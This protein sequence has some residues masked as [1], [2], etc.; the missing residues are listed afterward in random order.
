MAVLARIRGN[1]CTILTVCCLLSCC[2]IQLPGSVPSSVSE[3]FLFVTGHATRNSAT[4]GAAS[5]RHSSLEI[6]T[7]HMEYS[8]LEKDLPSDSLSA[9]VIVS[10]RWSNT[11][12]MDFNLEWNCTCN[13]T[14]P[15]PPPRQHPFSIWTTSTIISRHCL[16]YCRHLLV[17]YPVEMGSFHIFPCLIC[18]RKQKTLTLFAA[19][20]VW[21]RVNIAFWA[22]VPPLRRWSSLYLPVRKCSSNQREMGSGNVKYGQ[23]DVLGS[24]TFSFMTLIYA[25]NTISLVKISCSLWYSRFTI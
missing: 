16:F 13:L 23:N 10:L 8:F 22:I 7:C 12:T 9:S 15:P 14:T 5:S 24:T 11:V 18:I 19:G 4:I 3:R 2:F 1:N 6:L 17:T 25:L 21:W 20:I